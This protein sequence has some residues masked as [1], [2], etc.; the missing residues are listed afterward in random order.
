M[1]LSMGVGTLRLLCQ[2]D[3]MMTKV[4]EIDTTSLHSL[5]STV[6]IV[7]PDAEVGELTD[8]GIVIHTGLYQVGDPETPLVSYEEAYPEGEE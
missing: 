1:I 7:F 6:R 5:I 8:R 2:K 4:T 3:L